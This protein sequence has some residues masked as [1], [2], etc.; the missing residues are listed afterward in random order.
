[1]K[2]VFL[3]PLL[4]AIPGIA[5]AEPLSFD[6][7]LARATANAPIL[8]ARAQQVRARQSAATAAGRLPDP[9]LGVGLENFP[10]SGPPAFSLTRENMTMERIGIEQDIPNLAKRR[11]QRQRA[12]ADIGAAES[13]DASDTRRVRTATALAW[14]NAVYAQKRLE[15]ME[16][17]LAKLRLLPAASVSAVASGAGRPAQS[18]SIE[19]ALAELEDRRSTIVA[20]ASSAQAELSRWTGSP[21]PQPV[22]GIPQFTVAPSELRASLERH[23]DLQMASAGAAQALANVRLARAE[24]RPDWGFNV[25]FQRRDP[26]FGN[27]VS[28]GATMSLPIFPGRR[29]NPRID[30]AVSDAA[31]ARAEQEDMRRALEAGLDTG[32]ADHVMHHEQW[33]RARDTL[34]PLARKRA[35]LETASYAAGRAGLLDAIDAQEMLARAELDALDREATVV[36]DA[37]QLVL[38]YGGEKQ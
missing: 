10:V 31:A 26:Q 17:I 3:V 14:I 21:D 12:N 19:Q 27:M 18:L 28:I 1:M 37:A 5:C 22:G 7:A 32:L 34:L 9:K 33:L 2:S 24:K 15:A 36:R 35:E 6:E 29:Q 16:G 11:A 25:A 23:P 8:E 13:R 4:A 20:E 38:T 30:A